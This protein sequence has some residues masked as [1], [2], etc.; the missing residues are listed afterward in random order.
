MI[1]GIV[2][3]GCFVAQGTSPVA[4]RHAAVHAAARLQLAFTR[5]ECLLH[6]S[7]IVNTVVNRT[8]ACLLAVNL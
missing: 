3:F 5:V 8:V 1:Q 7:E 6:L 4:E 2:P